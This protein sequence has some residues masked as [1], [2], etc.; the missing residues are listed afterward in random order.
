MLRRQGTR[1]RVNGSQGQAGGG[2]S[3]ALSEIGVGATAHGKRLLELGY[4][5]DQV[6]HGYGDV[7]QAISDMAVERDA[8]FK[9]DEFRT[10]NRCLDNAIAESVVEFSKQRD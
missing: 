8:P 1:R 2:V 4:T 10:L 5:V 6:V 9:V 7:C 3:V